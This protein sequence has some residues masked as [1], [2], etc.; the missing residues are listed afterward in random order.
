MCKN[1]L[2]YIYKGTHTRIQDDMSRENKTTFQTLEHV[3]FVLIFGDPMQKVCHSLVVM[4]ISYFPL[5]LFSSIHS[6]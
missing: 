2:V 3:R 5:K 4:T 6:I 1:E